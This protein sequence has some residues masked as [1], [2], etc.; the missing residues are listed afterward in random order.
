[1]NIFVVIM[2]G[3]G[4]RT[5]GAPSRVVTSTNPWLS[6]VGDFNNDGKLD[7]AVSSQTGNTVNVLLGNGDG[8]FQPKTVYTVGGSPYPLAIADLNGDGSPDLIVPNPST[9]TVGVLL[10]TQWTAAA[11]VPVYPLLIPFRG[12]QL[13]AETR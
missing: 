1:M 12:Q 2:L 8:T 13:L 3:N 9:S 5:F 7:L 11:S 10:S 6:A 4:D